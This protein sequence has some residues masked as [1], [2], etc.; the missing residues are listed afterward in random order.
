MQFFQMNMLTHGDLISR[1]E[2]PLLVTVL[3]IN[4]RVETPN[5]RPFVT[6]NGQS[7]LTES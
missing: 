3:V 7:Q 2:D 5:P 4:F 1:T 6:V